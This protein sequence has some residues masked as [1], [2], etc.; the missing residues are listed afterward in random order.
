M[1]SFGLIVGGAAAYACQLRLSGNRECMGSINYRFALSNPTLVSSH[2]KKSFYS[3]SC[4]IFACKAFT[5]ISWSSEVS[6][7][8]AKAAHSLNCRYQLVIWLGCISYCCASSASVFS[9]AN[10]TFALNAGECFLLVPFVIFCTFLNP[11]PG[12]IGS[13]FST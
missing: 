5:S 9:P 13:R 7:S 8:N 3:V 11:L 2:S 4:P 10:A 6:P 1:N 12:S